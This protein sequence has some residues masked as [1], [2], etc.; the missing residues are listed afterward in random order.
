M[1]QKNDDHEHDDSK[2]MNGDR[3]GRTAGMEQAL[4]RESR[5]SA[6]LRDS[7][8]TLQKT[9]AA[10]EASFDGKLNEVVKRAER[11]ETKIKDQQ[12]RLN[13]L[14]A[15][16]EETM[17]ALNETRAEL[18][19]AKA[20]RDRLQKKLTL[21]DGMQTE[22]IALTEDSGEH[23]AFHQ[24]LPSIEELMAGLSS[25]EEVV[26]DADEDLRFDGSGDAPAPDLI[27]ADLI[28]PEE[29]ASDRPRA[30]TTRTSTRVLVYLDAH[31][32]IKYPLYKDVITIGRS[33]SADIQIDDDFIS[34]IHAR[35]VSDEYRTIVEDVD[36]KNGIKVNSRLIARHALQHGDVIGLGKLRFT[37]VETSAERID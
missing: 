1:T 26:P 30:S 19:R 27:P 12:A 36:S 2:S 24:A 34:R 15:G 14:G 22:T 23:P 16:R 8:E 7:L 32:P 5:T 25:F 29:T 31:P 37:F 20:D 21:I 11:A 10:I 6:A 4:A 18:A 17:R 3:P 35:I 33:T 13:A 9:V 28:F